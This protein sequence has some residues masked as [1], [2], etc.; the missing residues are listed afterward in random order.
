MTQNPIRIGLIG[1]GGNTRSRHI[2]GFQA[3]QDDKVSNTVG[4]HDLQL[5]QVR[6]VFEN[7][8]GRLHRDLGLLRPRPAVADRRLLKRLQ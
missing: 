6:V 3:Q 7:T 4:F 5:Q 8:E 1:A 2:P